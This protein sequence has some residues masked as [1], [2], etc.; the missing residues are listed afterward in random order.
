MVFFL[1]NDVLVFAQQGN[2]FASAFKLGSKKLKVKSVCSL[3]AVSVLDIPESDD[4]I[5]N[6]SSLIICVEMFFFFLIENIP[7]LYFVSILNE[8]LV[9]LMDIFSSCALARNESYYISNRKH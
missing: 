1:F 5:L 6:N 8:M 2:S 9:Q 7:V 4:R 3:H